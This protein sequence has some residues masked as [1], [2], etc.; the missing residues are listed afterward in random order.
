MLE[1]WNLPAAC[2]VD[3]VVFKKHFYENT[4]LSAA[5]KK[6]FTDGIEKIV[7]Q[8]SIKEENSFIRPYRDDV[9][10]YAE[11]EVFVV[12]LHH[13]GKERRIAE[14][15]MRAIPYP[16]LLVLRCADQVQLWA[17]H[18]RNSQNDSDKNVLEELQSTT[19]I[20]AEELDGL[21]RFEALRKSDF[22]ALYTDMVD[23]VSTFQAKH[24]LGRTAL[25]GDEARAL[26]QKQEA[27]EAKLTVLR[28]QLKKETQFNRKVELSME[29]KKLE[30][31]R[32]NL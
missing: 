29:I 4:D 10:E 26:L 17:A 28:A 31:E 25:S 27:L 32:E 21:F 2:L 22:Y 20:P 30:K 15:L 24:L 14:I 18:Q 8:Y 6:L 7:W 12:Q 1:Q 13:Q 9:R 5:D 3:S 11:V 19:W 16:M 23:A